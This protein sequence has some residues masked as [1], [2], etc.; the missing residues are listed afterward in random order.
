MPGNA[1]RIDVMLSY[2]AP[3]GVIG[4]RLSRVLT[5]AFGEKVKDDV[6]RFKAYFEHAG[7]V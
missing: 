2:R 6:Y 4:Q 7:V 5:P 1:T 3:A